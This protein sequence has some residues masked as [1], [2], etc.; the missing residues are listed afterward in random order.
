MDKTGKEKRLIGRREKV[1]FPEFGLFDIEAKI[2]TG[3]YTT[4][5]HCHR[6]KIK[7]E[8]DKTFLCFNL[9][10]P[11][12]P[13]YNEKQ[14]CVE[15]FSKKEIKN[16]FGD[17]EERFIIQ[18]KIKIGRKIINTRVSLTD[19]GNMRYPVLVGRKILKNR[20]LI[21]VA[22][23]YLTEKKLRRKKKRIKE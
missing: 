21:D 14:H 5:L 3:A 20:F 11:S 19:R 22:E 10:D 16:S 4:A 1:S 2:D 12:H 9:L 8:N 15:S 17:L 6:I 18:T 7:T 13:E 23:T